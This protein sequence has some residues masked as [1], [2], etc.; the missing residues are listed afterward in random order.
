MQAG[1]GARRQDFSEKEQMA[2]LWSIMKPLQSMCF[3][4]RDGCQILALEIIL[5][6]SLL[7]KRF[8]LENKEE[9]ENMKSG[10]E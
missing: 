7:E 6:V 1:A 3:V 9:R 4:C 2:V 10:Q 5:Q 8:N